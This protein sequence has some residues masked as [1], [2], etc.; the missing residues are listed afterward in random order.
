MNKITLHINGRTLQVAPDISVAAALAQA[1]HSTTRVSES[2][3]PRTAFC[4][5]GICQE[6]RVQIDNVAQRLACLTAVAEGMQIVS[7]AA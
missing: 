1:D 6:C 7:G 4:G 2:G 3:Q 5:M